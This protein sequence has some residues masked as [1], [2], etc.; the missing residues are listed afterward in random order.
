M[1]FNR[2]FDFCLGNDVFF[3]RFQFLKKVQVFYK[4][5]HRN[6]NF[7]P[8]HIHIFL[9]VGNRMRMTR[10]GK[11][12]TNQQSQADQKAGWKSTFRARQP[13]RIADWVGIS[14]GHN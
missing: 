6:Q 7:V 8:F 12:S 14:H 4:N 11:Q 9:A 1:L 13:L 2:F 3:I 10:L 5:L